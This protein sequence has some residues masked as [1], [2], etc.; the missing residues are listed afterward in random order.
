MLPEKFLARLNTAPQKVILSLAPRW[1]QLPPEVLR[2]DE[3]FLPYGK[4]IVAATKDA[5]GGYL[6]S[7]PAYLSTGAS[8]IIA[9]ERTLAYASIS[10]VLTIL[11]GDFASADY[12]AAFTHGELTVDAVTVY[13]AN[14]CEAFEQAGITAI[15]KT[16][17]ISEDRI[18]IVSNQLHA[19]DQ[20]WH[21]LQVNEIT[22]GSL[23]FEEALRMYFMN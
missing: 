9:L 19:G 18:T 3:P 2:Y 21:V 5:V 20:F 10:E 14:L 1:D 17:A 16:G 11:D 12:V 22:R 8:G 15:V 13:L 6:F 4:A 23:D 7:L